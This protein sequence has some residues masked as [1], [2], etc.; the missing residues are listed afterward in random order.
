MRKTQ[1]GRLYKVSDLPPKKEL[2]RYIKKGDS[3]QRLGRQSRAR[4]QHEAKAHDAE[5]AKTDATCHKRIEQAIE[6]IAEGKKR[7][8]KYQ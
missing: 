3:P 1:F 4:S 8:W 2:I 5:A 6:W 7:N